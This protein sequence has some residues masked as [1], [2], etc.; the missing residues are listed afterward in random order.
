M[1]E[2]NVDDASESIVGDDDA[3]AAPTEPATE[4]PTELAVQPEPV[5]QPD[6]QPEPAAQPSLRPFRSASRP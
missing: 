4:A 6:T 3:G 5:V 1:N 2:P